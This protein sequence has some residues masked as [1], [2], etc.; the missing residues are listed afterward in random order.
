[1]VL[2]RSCD[3]SCDESEKLYI[4]QK[5]DWCD[6]NYDCGDMKNLNILVTI[7]IIDC[8]LICIT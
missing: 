1:M 6:H 8:N 7:M 3:Y 2:N 4:V 5:Y